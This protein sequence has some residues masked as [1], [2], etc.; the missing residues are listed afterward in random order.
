MKQLTP[1]RAQKVRKNLSRWLEVRRATKARDYLPSELKMAKHL[2]ELLA[3]ANGGGDSLPTDP[4]QLAELY[5]SNAVATPQS[6]GFI[7]LLVGAGVA[8]YFLLS[9]V[10][11]WATKAKE[12]R[13]MEACKAGTKEY[14]PTPWGT[15]AVIAGGLFA[16]WYASQKGYLKKLTK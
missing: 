3:H 12:E 2:A 15:Y 4:E 6:Q 1:Y 11:S 5:T 10:D 7:P 16:L 13:E 9:L 14:C 8:V